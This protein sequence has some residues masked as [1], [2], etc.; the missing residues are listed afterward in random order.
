VV[1]YSPPDGWEQYY[2]CTQR[3]MG[4]NQ[5]RPVRYTHILARHTMDGPVMAGLARK[6]DWHRTLLKDPRR[7]LYGYADDGDLI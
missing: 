7:F 4:P 1:F 3:V 5:H 2:Q 6:E